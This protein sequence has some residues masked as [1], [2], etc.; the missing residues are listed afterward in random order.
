MSW[1]SSRTTTWSGCHAHHDGCAAVMAPGQWT[2][3]RYSPHLLRGL[4]L[5]VDQVGLPMWLPGQCK[6]TSPITL[7]PRPP[8]RQ[9]PA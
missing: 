5:A 3:D 4:Q 1:L 7:S 2:H 8:L 9:G 6:G